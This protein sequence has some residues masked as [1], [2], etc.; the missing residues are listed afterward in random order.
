IEHEFYEV[1]TFKNRADFLAKSTTYNLWFNA[2]RKN[3]YKNHP[4]PW[5][6]LQARDPTLPKEIVA[7]PR[8]FR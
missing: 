2:A 6:I 8:L 4:S 3:S 5:E 1:E 7:F